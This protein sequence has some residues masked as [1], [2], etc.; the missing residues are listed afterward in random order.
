MLTG[1]LNE[2]PRAAINFIKED[3]KDYTK[4]YNTLTDIEE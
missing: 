2:H 3:R 1:Q 4:F